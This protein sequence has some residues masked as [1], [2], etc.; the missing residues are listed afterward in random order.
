MVIGKVSSILTNGS[1]GFLKGDSASDSLTPL[2]CLNYTIS[3]TDRRVP[4]RGNGLSIDLKMKCATQRKLHRLS[5]AGYIKSFFF[6]KK[7]K[8]GFNKL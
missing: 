5:G 2:S 4:E 6:R 7:Y 8:D 3:A 1:L